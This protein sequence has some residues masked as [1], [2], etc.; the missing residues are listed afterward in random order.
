MNIIWIILAVGLGIAVLLGAGALYQWF[1]IRR[2]ARLYPPPGQMAGIG[3]GNRI[4]LYSLGAGSPAVV[5][6]SGISATCL[7]WRGV[8]NTLASLTRVVAYDRAGLGWSDSTNTPRT[9]SQIAAE[10]HAALDAAGIQPPWIL[11]GHSF[12]GLVVRRFALSYPDEVAGL[13]LVDPLAPEEWSPLSERNR[14]ILALGIRLA[15]RGAFLARIGLVRA[16]VTLVMSGSRWL[17]K[18]IGRCT[19]GR[20]ATAINRIV[21]EVGKMPREVWPMVAAQWA[22]PRSFLGMAA[23][24]ESLPESAD[25]MMRTPPIEGIPV[26]VL[27]AGN[28]SPAPEEQI[29]AIATNVRHVVARGC[30]HWIHLD[31]PDL[32]VDAVRALVQ[33]VSPEVR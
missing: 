3:D 32:V 18:A 25:E 17:P 15:R 22:H 27:T 11:A 14:R 21:G 10:L 20:G 4:H 9:P 33:T 29:R 5:L 7:N 6:E 12:G 26:T 24:F 1:G 30:G 2:D 13:V 23:H 19:S 28:N 8:Q 31:Q 16:A